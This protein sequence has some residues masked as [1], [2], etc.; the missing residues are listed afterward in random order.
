MLDRF[1]RNITYLRI[2]VTDRCNLRCRY[3]MPAEGV[4]WI[5]HAGI[6]RFEEITEVVKVAVRLGINKIRLTGGEPLVRKGIQELVRMIA[7][8]EGV[9]D[10]AVTTNGILLE[11][12]AAELAAAGLH[13]V[14]VSLDT[15]DPQKY[16]TLT[17]GGNLIDVLKGLEAARKE[18]LT[19]IKVNCVKTQDTAAEDILK[20][21]NFCDRNG[22]ELRFIHQMSLT[23]GTFAPVEG[24]DGGRC[25]ICN[26]IRLT[27]KGELVSCLFSEN[28]YNIREYG[29]EEA[30]RIAIG[31]K[32]ATGYKNKVHS[33]YNIGG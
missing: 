13:R 3:C 16:A 4:E 24:G 2:S 20:L 29:I 22:Y 31:K 10:L 26:R 1:N 7:A 15:L 14:N 25:H 9:K 5:P 27:A 23:E 17:R 12:Y 32:P 30:I 19:P 28:G 18:G 21:R 8:V 11:K 33:F 6:L